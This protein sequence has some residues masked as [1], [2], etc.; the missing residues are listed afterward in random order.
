[1]RIVV[2]RCWRVQVPGS[3]KPRAARATTITPATVA[4]MAAHCT[5]EGR[6]PRAIQK[7]TTSTGWPAT[8]GATIVTGPRARAL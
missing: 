2:R 1:M 4:A 3:S 5:A 6:V 7:A 8:M